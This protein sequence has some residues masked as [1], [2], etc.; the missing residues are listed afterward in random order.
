MSN[1]SLEKAPMRELVKVPSVQGKINELVGKRS[2]AFCTT[3]VQMSAQPQ[4]KKCSA[5]SIMGAAM[6]AATMDLPINQNLGFAYVVPYGK[7]AQF[8][9]GYKGFIQLA[10]RTGQYLAMNDAII[11]HGCLK[12]YNE[13]TGE[14]IVDFESE[15]RDDLEKADGYAFYFELLNGFKKTVFWSTEKI[16]KHAERYSQSY[17]KGFGPWSDNFDAMALKTVI[18]LTLGKYGVLSVDIQTALKTDQSVIDP[19]TEEAADIDY[20]DNKATEEKLAEEIT[21]EPE[22]TPFDREA[23]IKQ[24]EEIKK[25]PK[26]NFDKACADCDV[27]VEMWA[28][29]PDSFLTALIEKLQA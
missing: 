17:R 11:P 25:D 18:K 19:L 27:P 20:A 4:L 9:M 22:A 3:L 7:E 6:T 1:I 16:E 23:T 28:E 5:M 10:Q 12:S 24:L 8:Q 14:L 2:A 15:D 26:S 21:E 13:L 29:A